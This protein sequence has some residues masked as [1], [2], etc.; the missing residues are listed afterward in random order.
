MQANSDPLASFILQTLKHK[1]KP[2]DKDVMD[3]LTQPK[4]QKSVWKKPKTR[5]EGLSRQIFAKESSGSDCQ[6]MGRVRGIEGHGRHD[7]IVVSQPLQSA[8]VR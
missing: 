2:T 4:K 6:E 8:T 3:K 5:A 1:I 7:S